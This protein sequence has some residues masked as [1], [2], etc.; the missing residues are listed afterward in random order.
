MLVSTTLNSFNRTVSMSENLRTWVWFV[1]VVLAMTI[2]PALL[3]TL[4]ICGVTAT[5]RRYHDVISEK[6]KS[7]RVRSMRLAHSGR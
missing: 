1:S 4:F 3:I 2:G 7:F 5:Y 6:M